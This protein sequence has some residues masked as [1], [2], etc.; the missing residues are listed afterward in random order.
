MK[1]VVVPTSARSDQLVF[2]PDS[3]LWKIIRENLILFNG[4]AAAVLQIS[5]PR[6]GLGVRDHSDF[7]ERPLDRLTRT[8]DAV[9]GIVFGTH[10]EAERVAASLR[11]LHTRVRGDAA[12]ANVPG[13]ATYRADEIDLLMWVL[14]TLVMS[15][16]L[17]YERLFGPISLE[18]KQ[19]FYNDMRIFGTYFDLPTTYGPQTWDEFNRY[20]ES[21]L[22]DAM[23]GSH[24]ISKEVAWAIARP[25]RPWYVMPLGLPIRILLQETL[26]SPVRERLSFRSTWF[27]RRC[28]AILTG[29]LRFIVP[30]L[31]PVLRY[32]LEYRRNLS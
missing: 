6:I 14:A 23:I 2:S 12:G 17:G 29:V 26:P 15:A 27:S 1:P 9:H 24:L 16:I 3:V 10:A 5:H 22:N 28:L 21:V 8:L 4:A 11:R 31:P 13:D 32:R 18:E 20:Y 30:L 25:T 19:S 7:R